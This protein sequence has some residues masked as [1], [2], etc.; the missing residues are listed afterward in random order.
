M[1]STKNYKNPIDSF[2]EEMEERESTETLSVP[3][4][5]QKTLET[6]SEQENEP[7][8]DD[9]SVINEQINNESAGTDPAQQSLFGDDDFE[10]ALNKCKTSSNERVLGNLAE[11][12]PVFK[13][14]SVNNPITDKEITFEALR[15][16][17]ETDF[18]EL[19]E[20]Q[21]VS[22]SVTYGKTTQTVTNPAKEKVFDVKGKIENSEK[23]ISD[24]KKAKTEGDKTPDCV[25]KPFVKAQKKGEA[26]LPPHKG[27]FL[28]A[29]DAVNS[30][31]AVTY[32]PS[33]SGR[34]YEIRK[35]PIGIFQSPAREIG[36]F[37]DLKPSFTIRLPKIPMFLLFQIIGFFRAVSEK[38]P[39]EA[40]VHILFDTKTNKYIVKIPKQKITRASV[41]S[42][43]E[44]YPENLI[45]VMD[46]HSHNTMR[47]KFSETDDNDEKVTRLYGVI[48]R[49]DKEI[50]DMELRASN[51]GKFINLKF[52]EIFDIDATYPESW[53]DEINHSIAEAICEAE[54]SEIGDES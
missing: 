10:A 54:N 3:E 23:F 51:G 16:Q 21:N 17:Y 19:E 46:I 31:K 12:N 43:L 42:I 25:V 44:E 15:K 39:L 1:N 20:K 53:A 22:W 27:F 24:L 50:P 28:N 29:E 36:E 7:D 13:Y 11:K 18:P 52:N 14:A 26:L 38:N 40:L 47:A 37:A 41:D 9:E 2:L 8:E 32:T 6:P 45:H 34:I 49:L 30:P 48:G 4:Q 5:E 35:N 33:K